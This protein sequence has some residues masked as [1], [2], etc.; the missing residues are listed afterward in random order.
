MGKT[1]LPDGFADVVISNCAINLCLDKDAVYEEAFLLLRPGGRVAISDIV[2]VEDISPEL[3]DRFESTWSGC[4]GG[5][6]PENEYLKKVKEVGFTEIEM[7]AH[8][9]LT[10]EEL[11]AM[12]R[13][14]GEEFTPPPAKEDLALVQG[15][16]EPHGQSPWHLTNAQAGRHPGQ[17]LAHSSTAKGRGF[18]LPG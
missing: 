18:L 6:V 1:N 14:P 4:P 11:E 2:L 16:V 17:E 9:V 10:P 8:H 13:C 15:R 7:L 3:R 12:A 5:A